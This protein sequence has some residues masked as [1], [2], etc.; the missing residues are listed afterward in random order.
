MAHEILFVTE[1]LFFGGGNVLGGCITSFADTQPNGS[2]LKQKACH[3]KV[4]QDAEAK[5]QTTKSP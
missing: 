1:H 4:C 5:S 2:P 3:L